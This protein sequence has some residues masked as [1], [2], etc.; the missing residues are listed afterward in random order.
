MGGEVQNKKTQEVALPFD[1][2]AVIYT[3]ADGTEI[4]LNIDMVKKYLITP[5]KSAE[6]VTAQEFVFFLN[7]CKSRGLNPFI[8][9]VYPVKY[10]EEP[11]AI[12]TSIDFL[13]KK[14]AAEADCEGW[15]KGVIVVNK[16]TKEI[17]ESHGIVLAT[18]ELI[19]GWFRGFKKGW[20]HDFYLEVNLSGYIKKTRDGAITK[21]WAPENQPTMIA[22]VAEAQGLRTMWPGK[23]SKM[24]LAEEIGTG[25]YEAPDITE[26]PE[27]IDLQTFGTFETMLEKENLTSDDRKIFDQ[28]CEFQAKKNKVDI[29]TLQGMAEKD[30]TN[31]MKYF[32]AYKE[33]N[34]PG[35]QTEKKETPKKEAGAADP[36]LFDNKEARGE[37]EKPTK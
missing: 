25:D 28:Y 7:I 35:K 32:R 23:F 13:R 34:S 31:F 17:R 12:I 15:D 29:Q 21:F 36:P 26:V 20:R 9:D 10:G 4:R 6:L 27:V 16:Q 8:K 11:L 24:Y 33:K 37:G 14:A 5:A 30:F 2:R 3:A 22:K 19:G 18:E 1:Q